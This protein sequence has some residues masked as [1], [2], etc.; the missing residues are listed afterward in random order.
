MNR[1]AGVVGIS[2]MFTVW[3]GTLSV[4]AVVFL[5]CWCWLEACDWR[6]VERRRVDEPVI[7]E[8]RRRDSEVG[9]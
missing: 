3:T 5:T 8:R 1:F 9:R 6:D 2:S 4:F 7:R